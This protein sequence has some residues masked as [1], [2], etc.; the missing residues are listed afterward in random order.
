[1]HWR[2]SGARILEP[3]PPAVRRRLTPASRRSY[4]T[5]GGLAHGRPV[6][7]GS[8]C[9]SPQS[10]HRAGRPAD[11]HHRSGD[12]GRR[13]ADGRR[14]GQREAG[15]VPRSPI[16]V[17]SDATGRYRF[18]ASRLEP[19]GIRCASAPSATI[20]P[21]R[22]RRRSRRRRTTTVDLKLHKT[23]DL[24]AQLSNAEW[25]ASFP[26]NEA[27]EGVDPQLH[28]LPH[29]RARSSRTRHDVDELTAVVERM[30]TYP[31]L[32]FPLKPQK[33]RGAADRRRRGSARSS[34]TRGWRRQARVSEHAQ[35]ERRAAV[36]LRVQDAAAAEG[37]R[38]AGHLHRIRPAAAHAAAARRDRRLERHRLVRE[39]RRA[40]P[41]QARSR[42]RQGHRVRRPAAEAEAPTGIL[43]LRFDE[44]ENLWMGMQ[45][46]GGV[47][48]FDQKTEKF[49]TWSLPPELNGDHVQI[50]QVSP[51]HRKVDGKVWLQDAGTYNVLRL[52]VEV[53]QVRGV[54]AIQD[55]AA[56]HLRRDSRSAEQ[57]VLHA[58]SAARTSDASTRRPARSRL[59]R[60][61]PQARGRAA[62]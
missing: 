60:R 53:R 25:L 48:K 6:R 3:A 13:R 30:S 9:G 36:E 10:D 12:V 11:R 34:S 20:S 29:A 56:E 4:A 41:R 62:A 49:Q 17:V 2:P 16:T 24:A 58:C 37:T 21:A 23:R 45:F 59:S 28:A 8:A 44:D 38:D 1:M 27:A 40:D 54:R 33:L 31:Q 32:S 18:P 35:S 15:R 52:D 7:R 43:A 46:Q 39:L 61:R 22:P 51:E 19:G 47:A 50:N 26:G 57:R 5:S 14:A 42:D 55:S